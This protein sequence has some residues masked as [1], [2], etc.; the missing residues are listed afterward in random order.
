MFPV[1]GL[2]CVQKQDSGLLEL[3]LE[4][5]PLSPQGS[6]TALLTSSARAMSLADAFSLL[7]CGLAFL[8]WVKEITMWAGGLVCKCVL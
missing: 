4:L 6:P 5:E 2:F 7:P 3:E 1:W 8:L